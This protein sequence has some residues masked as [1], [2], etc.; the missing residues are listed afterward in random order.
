MNSNKKYFFIGIGGIGMSSIARYFMSLGNEVMGYDREESEIVEK[1]SNDGV[2]VLH[3][4]DIN[5]LSD[6]F[7]STDVIVVYTSAIS[8]ENPYL[9]YFINN[10]NKVYK[11]S[12]ILGEITENTFCIGIAGTHGKTTTA[13]ILTHLFY[14]CEEDFQSFV[15][16]ILNGYETNFIYRSPN[17]L[18]LLN[19]RSPSR[20]SYS[21][22][23]ADEYDRS[24]LQLKPNIGII[25]SIE[26]DHLDIYGDFKSLK[27]SFQLFADKVSDF[28]S[29]TKS[30]KIFYSDEVKGF[31]GLS[32]SINSETD[33]YLKNISLKDNGYKFDLITPDNKFTNVEFNQIGTHNLLNAL[34]AFSVAHYLGLDEDKLIEALADFK[35]VNRRMDVFRLGNKIVIDDYAHHPSE[36]NVVLNSIKDR[37]KNMEVGVI[38]QPH[39]FSRTKDL[40]DD[41]AK[42][43]SKFDEVYLLDIYPAR[44]EPIEGINSNVLLEKIICKKKDIIKIESINQKI[45]SI[46]SDIIAVLGAGNVANSIQDLKK[47]YYEKSI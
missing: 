40:L 29:Y 14:R 31:E 26:K 11:R 23:E 42:V 37:Y 38:F 16:G 45:E 5:L 15:G 12:E 34:G 20:F 25:T 7:K 17:I 8:E 2:K 36:I 30:A 9:K 19:G 44:E 28:L 41:F 33:Y 21:I 39:L 47:K 46:E 1:L 43:L 13:A 3:T 22:V 27:E 24:F 35:G 4:I 10:K 32:Y 6:Y 18:E